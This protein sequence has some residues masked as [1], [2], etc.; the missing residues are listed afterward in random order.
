MH[1]TID[2]HT[3]NTSMITCTYM[4]VKVTVYAYMHIYITQMF[5]RQD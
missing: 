3:A 1:R 5:L 2:F 4:Q